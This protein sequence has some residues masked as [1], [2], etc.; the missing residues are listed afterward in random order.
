MQSDAALNEIVKQNRASSHSIVLS[1]EH[2]DQPVR[3]TIAKRRQSSLQLVPV[4]AAAVVGVEAT[5]TV[6]PVG[7]VSEKFKFM[8]NESEMSINMNVMI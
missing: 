4:D 7:D 2:I 6:L 5:E 8:R 1:H 3:E